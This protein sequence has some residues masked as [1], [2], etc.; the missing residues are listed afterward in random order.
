MIE[1][2]TEVLKFIAPHLYLPIK[3]WCIVWFLN[4]FEPLKITTE[5]IFE[6]LEDKYPS[7]ITSIIWNSVRLLFTCP[8]CQTFWITLLLSHSFIMSVVLAYCAKQLDFG[9]DDDTIDLSKYNK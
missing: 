8:T 3:V 6:K 2:I 4:N 1:T 9:D 5:G 7:L